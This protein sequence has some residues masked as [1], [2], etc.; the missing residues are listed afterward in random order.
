MCDSLGF[1][2]SSWTPMQLFITPSCALSLGNVTTNVLCNGGSTGSI[3]LSV[4]GGTGSYS[5]LWSNG[6]TT[7]DLSGL[8]P[9]LYTVTVTDLSTGCT[10][11]SSISITQNA[12]IVFN[13]QQ[14][15]C[16]GD[17]VVIGS[18]VYTSAGIYNDTLT[19]SNGCDSIVITSLSVIPLLTVTVNPSGPIDICNGTSVTLSSSTQNPNF[20]YSWTD[21][22]GL[23][24]GTSSRL[25]V[26]SSGVYNV[27]VTTT[28]GCAST[29]TNSVTVNVISLPAPSILS[30]SNITFT[31]AK[32]NWN[33]VAGANHYDVRVREVGTTS[34]QLF[35]NI[36]FTYQNK[37]GLTQAST[38]EW[39]VRTACTGDSSSVSSWSALEVFNTL[40]PC[41][42]P[43]NLSSTTGWASATLDWDDVSGAWGYRVRYKSQGGSW[44][45]DTVNTSNITL[46]GLTSP[47][48]TWQVKSMCDSLGL[49]S[50]VWST[51]QSFY[52]LCPV[53]IN[54]FT[55][56]IT[57]TS[58]KFN[59]SSVVG[60]HHYEIRWREI[61]SSWNYINSVYGN[62]R[63]KN[64]LTLGTNYEWQI[65][66]SCSSDSSNVSA[67]SLSDLFSTQAACVKPINPVTSNITSSSADLSWDAVPGAI[68]YKI[69]W[70]QTGVSGVNVDTVWATNILSLSGLNSSSTYKWKVRSICD[71]ST[72]NSSPFTSWTFFT[73][74]SGAKVISHTDSEEN[75]I[76][77]LNI[78][79][80]PSNG[81]LNIEF[82]V[83]N[84]ENFN[85]SIIDALGNTILLENKKNY[86][87]KYFKV[88]EFHNYNKGIYILR[89]E[90][91]SSIITRRLV[92]Q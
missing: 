88:F 92:L 48:Y 74:L 89:I 72:N 6:A 12:P 21:A 91:N 66:T 42:V 11:T 86:E 37:Y 25:S 22:T 17:S 57:L 44:S 23:V 39:Q 36:A 10:A 90:N 18:S 20:S 35:T 4:S 43:T 14:S 60:A 65:R 24:V 26:S 15:I 1:N 77:S 64:N 34:W 76:K 58:A 8:T 67:W 27:T 41:A 56:N 80:N 19:A 63:T 16:D 46:T 55:T 31:S 79:P 13:N 33:A 29:S 47:T 9:G 71:T 85:L 45:Y 52:L 2:T 49:N 59:W 28:S 38:Y 73:T 87:G 70:R 54:I 83:N 40:T 5:Y 7:E 51:K 68:G 84:H 81:K 62:S 50:S 61:G 53:P 32:L 78:Y 30:T 3:D 69:K 82:D 75:N